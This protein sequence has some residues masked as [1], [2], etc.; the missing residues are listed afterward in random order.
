MAANRLVTAGRRVLV[1]VKEIEHAAKLSSMIAGSVAVDGRDNDRVDRMLLALEAGTVSAVVG[2]SVIGE[3]RDVPA[4]DA[5]VYASGGRSKV[6]VVQDYFR[7]L[8]ASAGKATA[9]VVD[10]ADTHHETL[11]D[12]AAHRLSHYRGE[13]AFQA[14]V[15]E[16][17]QF[18]AWLDDNRTSTP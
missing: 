11:L 9:I 12:H 18:D 16:P 15:I 17:S 3:G 4:A 6:R 5:L 14:T 7:A 8:T 1:L 2:T 13:R 10:A